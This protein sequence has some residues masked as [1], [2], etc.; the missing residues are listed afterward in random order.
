VECYLDSYVPEETSEGEVV[1]VPQKYSCGVPDV[2][3]KPSPP[4]AKVANGQTAA[5]GSQPWTASIRV[6]GNTKS[7]HWCGAVIITERHV[8]TAAHCVEDYPKDV[9]LV[10]VGDWDQDVEDVGEKEFSIQ[11]VNF[12]PEFNIGA[13]LS[14]DIAVLTLKPQSGKSIQFTD[15]IK[16][17][18]LPSETTIYYPG[19]ECT[20]SGWGSTGQAA[21]GYARRLQ[22]AKVPILKTEE[23]MKKQVYGP[24]KLTGGMF[25]AGFLEGGI[26]SCQGDSG[27]PM[28]CQNRGKNEL[29]G[30]ISWG[31]G[32]G[33]PNKPGVYTRVVS[34]LDW[35]KSIIE[36]N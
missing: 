19:K 13:Y 14:N 10:R 4:I 3:Y 2:I 6:K 23:C 5:P 30:I 20:I 25:C 32:C 35:I 36:N 7:F 26:D 8:L 15:K 21:G 28:V 27:G 17:A 18:C 33:R 9:Y 16:P 34:Y 22:S 1:N 12:H 31:Y 29:W 11:T 24:D